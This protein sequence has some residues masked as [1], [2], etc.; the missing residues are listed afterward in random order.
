MGRKRRKIIKKTPKPFPKVYTCPLCGAV[1]VTVIHEKGQENATVSCGNC[2][3]SA[4]IPWY[5]SYSTVD[6]YTKWYDMVT[7]GEKTVEAGQG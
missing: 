6:A 4:D 3:A 2:K 5:P 7:R 1:A